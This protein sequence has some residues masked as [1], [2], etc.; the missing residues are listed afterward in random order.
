[1][2]YC[3]SLCVLLCCA[4]SSL[5]AGEPRE[6]EGRVR[7]AYDVDFEMNFDNREYDPSRFSRQVL[8][9]VLLFTG[10]R[11][12]DDMTVLTAGIWKRQPGESAD[13]NP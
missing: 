11:V 3:I 2:K 8:E 7:F 5:Y 12:R 1:M 13:P 9:Q 6:T 10:G 4:V